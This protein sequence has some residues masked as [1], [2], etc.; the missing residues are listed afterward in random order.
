MG[1]LK[2]TNEKAVLK[3]YR[4]SCQMEAEKNSFDSQSPSP[5]TELHF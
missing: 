3:A 5:G 2:C 4:E 1:K